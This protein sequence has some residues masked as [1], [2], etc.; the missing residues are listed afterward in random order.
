LP[1][2]NPLQKRLPIVTTFVFKSQTNFTCRSVRDYSTPI[3][4]FTTITLQ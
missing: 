1:F 2:P 4:D 3:L